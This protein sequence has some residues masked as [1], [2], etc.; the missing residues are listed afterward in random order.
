M[1]VS[2]GVAVAVGAAGAHGKSTNAVSLGALSNLATVSSSP[3]QPTPTAP[4]ATARSAVSPGRRKHGA[5]PLAAGLPPVQ[6]APSDLPRPDPTRPASTP[7]PTAA[8]TGTNGSAADKAT[9]EADGN[10]ALST[11]AGSTVWDSGTNG[12]SGALPGGTRRR[13]RRH[14]RRVGHRAMEYR[15]QREIAVRSLTGTVAGPVNCHELSQSGPAVPVH[16]LPINAE[17]ISPSGR[18]A[19]RRLAVNSFT[20]Q[21]R[22]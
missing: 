2:A 6:P 19:N 11:K 22:I 4:T 1:G 7:R 8:G 15:H 10:L 3:G 18:S 16:K 21:N 17:L 14:L 12:N 5:T 20:W 9:T 13:Q